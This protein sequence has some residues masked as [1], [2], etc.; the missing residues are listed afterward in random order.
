MKIKPNLIDTH[1]HINSREF[2]KDI[3]KVIKDS[4]K[5]GVTEIWDVATDIESSIKSLVI[6]SNYPNVKSFIGIDP[7]NFIPGSEFFKGFKDDIWFENQNFELKNLIEEN[8]HKIIGLGE[9]G[10]D[11]YWT[12]KLDF[13]QQRKSLEQQEKMFRLHLELAENTGLPLTIH[14]RNAENLCIKICQ[15]YNATGIFH[16]YTGDYETAKK[17]IDRGFGLGINGIITF[18][19]AGDLRTVYRKILG[20]ISS[21]WSVEDFYKKGVFFETD[22]PFLSPEGKRGEKNEPGNVAI[23]YDWVT[24]NL[25]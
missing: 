4:V 25:G 14:S 17:I 10:I 7:E 3:E 24:R 16:S 2:D 20:K 5:S 18:R 11:N 13:E 19:N 9:T 12:K 22:S 1:A 6:S 15:N 21:D 23:I 8:H